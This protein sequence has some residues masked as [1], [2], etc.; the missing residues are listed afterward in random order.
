MLIQASDQGGS[1]RGSSAETLGNLIQEQSDVLGGGSGIRQF[2]CLDAT[3]HNKSD[4]YYRYVVTVEGLDATALIV[5]NSM[6]RVQRSLDTLREY[7]MEATKP[8]P[9]FGSVAPFYSPYVKWFVDDPGA[10]TGQLSEQEYEPGEV[11][12]GNFDVR[13][14]RFRPSFLT[15]FWDSSQG[16]R[17]PVSLALDDFMNSLSFF[18]T[19]TSTKIDTIRQTLNDLVNPTVASPHSIGVVINMIETFI[20]KIQ[21]ILSTTQTVSLED[22]QTQTPK[23]HIPAKNRTF[24]ISHEFSDFFDANQKIDRGFSFFTNDLVDP[25]VG[26]GE[27]LIEVPSQL[28]DA[29][30]NLQ[31]TRLFGQAL[32]NINV[33]IP[34][35]LDQATAG[36][37]LQFKSHGSYF[38]PSFIWTQGVSRPEINNMRVSPSSNPKDF[39]HIYS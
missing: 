3:I 24:K 22:H 23:I 39:L 31:A 18:S 29:S 1:I 38:S 21:D 5:G 34:Q 13:S 33:N 36:F 27:G 12:P 16:Y 4:G 14:G 7:Y 15:E 35:I 20:S 19:L 11:R 26:Q 32:A 10:T 9:R 17:G 6:M 30:A 37:K 28:I 2:S 25:L 8:S